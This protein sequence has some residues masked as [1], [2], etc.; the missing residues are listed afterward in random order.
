MLCYLSCLTHSKRYQKNF[1]TLQ[2]PLKEGMDTK[3]GEKE[4]Q[5]HDEFVDISLLGCSFHTWI[6]DLIYTLD[7]TLPNFAT[8]SSTIQ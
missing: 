5:R 6:D 8:S 4:A 7:G 1:I 3:G 2:I